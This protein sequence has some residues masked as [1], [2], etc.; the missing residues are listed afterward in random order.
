MAN[1]LQ[2]CSQLTCR[3]TSLRA[4]SKL[5]RRF[6]ESRVE[7]LTEMRQVI[8]TPRGS[9]IPDG[10]IYQSSVFE[11]AST[12]GLIFAPRWTVRPTD[13]RWRKPNSGIVRQRVLGRQVCALRKGHALICCSAQSALKADGIAIKPPLTRATYRPRDD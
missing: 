11:I 8:K 3:K 12:P 9:G 10:A 4:F 5:T 2:R 1:C 7:R 13:R 6:A